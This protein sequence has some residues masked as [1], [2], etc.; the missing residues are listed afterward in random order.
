MECGVQQYGRSQSIRAGPSGEGGSAG[1][2]WEGA[3]DSCRDA[4]LEQTPEWTAEG[5]HADSW[6]EKSPGRG[7]GKRKGPEG[8]ESVLGSPR[9][10]MRGAHG[11]CP[12]RGAQGPGHVGGALCAAVRTLPF[13]RVRRMKRVWEGLHQARTWSNA[14]R[15]ISLWLLCGEWT[16]AG[17]GRRRQDPQTD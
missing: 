17:Q 15:E 5:G 8:R 7:D 2:K 13:C 6:G 12:P 10:W 14:S 16:T 9:G 3:G 1:L 4:A 11:K